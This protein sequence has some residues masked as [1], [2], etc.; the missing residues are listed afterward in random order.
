[1][2]KHSIV[3]LR[4]SITDGLN[5]ADLELVLAKESILNTRFNNNRYSRSVPPSNKK[6]TYTDTETHINHNKP[7]IKESEDINM[8]DDTQDSDNCTATAT[9]N[10]DSKKINAFKS[11]APPGYTESIKELELYSTANLDATGV[12]EI[13]SSPTNVLCL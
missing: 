12:N 8:E 9:N 1:L 6:H 13:T 11:V 3:N 10:K 7:N 5:Q 2:S 4:N